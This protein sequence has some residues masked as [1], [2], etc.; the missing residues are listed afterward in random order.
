MRDRLRA[1]SI[2]SSRIVRAVSRSMSPMPTRKLSASLLSNQ[3]GASP[4][5]KIDSILSRR[6]QLVADLAELRSRGGNSKEIGL[7]Q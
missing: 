4:R 7:R 5:G 1:P 3:A 6:E 2:A